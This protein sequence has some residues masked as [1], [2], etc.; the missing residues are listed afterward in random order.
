M[1]NKDGISVDDKVKTTVKN[2]ERPENI[3]EVRK[4]MG[5]LNYYRRFIPN[6][7][8][9]VEP[10]LSL[11]RKG[12]TFYWGQ[13]CEAA[14]E[15]I[16]DELSA[17][18]LL[19]FPDFRL[20][21]ILETDASNIGV[22]GVLYQEEY[23]ERRV[24]SFFSRSL[25]KAEKNYG[26]TEKEALAVVVSVKHFNQ[27]LYGKKF[28]IRTDHQC[29]KYLK[30]CGDSPNARLQRWCLFMQNYNYHVEYIRGKDNI[31]ADYLSRSVSLIEFKSVSDGYDDK[32]LHDYL[33][34][35]IL[36]EESQVKI[37]VLKRAKKYHLINGRL[38][39][40]TNIGK[41]VIVPG[42]LE[43][44]D[45][46]KKLHEDTGH[47]N[48]ETLY[49]KVEPLFY[50]PHLK[51]TC[52]EFVKSCRVCIKVNF[53]M[54]KQLQPMTQKK[55]KLFH[56]FSI[57][58]IGPL[59]ISEQFRFIVCAVE[60]FTNWTIAKATKTKEASEIEAFIYEDII[61]KFGPPVEI[62]TDC[63]KEYVNKRIQRLCHGYDIQHRTTSP[64]HPRAN[65][66]IEVTNREVE[67]RLRKT[68]VDYADD[69]W[70]Q[71]LPLIVYRMNCCP[72]GD[73]PSAFF[74]LY[75]VI[76]SSTYGIFTSKVNRLEE[77]E[78]NHAYKDA[79]RR[80]YN[81]KVLEKRNELLRQEKTFT[82]G[83]II[84][85]KV[86]NQKKLQDNFKGPYVICGKLYY[87]AYKIIDPETGKITVTNYENM[88]RAF[89]NP[90]DVDDNE[91]LF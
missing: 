47:S 75:G 44:N 38:C 23:G 86:F 65:G 59:P 31:E 35:G 80:T 11:T 82:K 76:P 48:F 62:I 55:Q 29:L 57:D 16:K 8:S 28:T 64:H 43:R 52:K 81:E 26:I 34:N 61:T 36:P 33:E 83:D 63:G 3:Q 6:F 1:I 87:G 2:F 17:N 49:W 56:S 73:M 58:T 90:G 70:S 20:P 32:E 12:K 54:K 51:Q 66:K 30:N 5:Y 69:N 9:K 13:A 88:K 45:I 25:K 46:L 27:Y 18:I 24:I 39:Y 53:A 60:N 10:I 68:M 7:S 79:L 71:Y 50:W 19:S 15:M 85:I 84:Y 78:L 21:F 22:A 40:I 37:C 42:V 74:L 77:L 4:L 91:S 89:V 72:K 41:R 14:F 67:K